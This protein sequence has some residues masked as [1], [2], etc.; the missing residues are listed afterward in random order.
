MP[1]R[2]NASYVNFSAKLLDGSHFR[3]P[4]ISAFCTRFDSGQKCYGTSILWSA[5]G[6]TPMLGGFHC[7]I[8]YG[9]ARESSCKMYGRYLFPIVSAFSGLIGYCRPTCCV[10]RGFCFRL[11]QEDNFTYHSLTPCLDSPISR[12]TRCYQVDS[13]ALQYLL[14]A[15]CFFSVAIGL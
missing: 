4:S 9:T 1:S 7:F 2:W 10:S 11:S 14:L 3:R 12:S 5:V 6:S 8:D 13:S 15:T